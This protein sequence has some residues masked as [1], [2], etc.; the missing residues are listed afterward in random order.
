MEI[1]S[2]KIF[3]CGRAGDTPNINAVAHFSPHQS[4]PELLSGGRLSKKAYCLAGIEQKRTK[5]HLCVCL[6]LS[7]RRK[8][9]SEE[10]R[11]CPRVIKSTCILNCSMLDF[12][13]LEHLHLKSPPKKK[14]ILRRSTGFLPPPPR[15]FHGHVHVCV[16]TGNCNRDTVVMWMSR[17][18]LLHLGGGAVDHDWIDRDL[19]GRHCEK[20]VDGLS[21]YQCV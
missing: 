21:I 16:A 3:F 14:K 19:C 12:L 17:R 6:S 20:T 9:S 18:K 10:I 4:F 2:F 5:D 11:E 7:Q 8:N 15:S 1:S 13:I